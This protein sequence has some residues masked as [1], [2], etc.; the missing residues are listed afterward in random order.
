MPSFNKLQR[1]ISQN[2]EGEYYYSV[3]DIRKEIYRDISL[4]NYIDCSGYTLLHDLIIYHRDDIMSVFKMV[5][6]LLN[7][8]HITNSGYSLLDVSVKYSNNEA[9]KY[10]LEEHNVD[11]ETKDFIGFT[12]LH[13]AARGNNLQAAQYILEYNAEINSKDNSNRKSI[14]IAIQYGNLEVV[15]LLIDHPDTNINCVDRFWNCSLL[16]TATMSKQWDIYEMLINKGID[17]N[18]QDSGGNTALHYAYRGYDQNAINYT[19]VNSNYDPTIK[20]SEGIT[21]LHIAAK[22]NFTGS[23]DYILNKE[24]I[25]IN[26]QSNNGNTPLHYAALHY[27]E[28]VVKILLER[29][30]D[31]YIENIKSNYPIDLAKKESIKSIIQDCYI[32]PKAAYKD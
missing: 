29:G 8:N 19:L 24:G 28:D 21:L 30:A 13:V 5:L 16:H 22:Q 26:V 32:G 15:K 12:P 9:V 6:P 7:I 25:D 3:E 2:H 14:D 11:T 1:I 27:S 4:I 10:L 18:I 23:V 20:N 17:V 31:P